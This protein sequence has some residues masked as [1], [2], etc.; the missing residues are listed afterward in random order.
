MDD[1]QALRLEFEQ[2]VREHFP[3]CLLPLKAAL[4]VVAINSFQHNQQPVTLIF[5]G[6]SSSGKTL[7]LSLINPSCSDEELSK[8][9][10]RCDSF[11]AKS[12]VSHCANKTKAELDEMDL[13]PRIENKTLITKELA[14]IFGQKEDE[15]RQTFSMLTSILDGRG[16][17]SNSGSQGQRGYNR[18]INFTW[19]GATT[20]PTNRAFRVMAQ[21]G[22][23][24]M[25]F[26]TFRKGKAPMIS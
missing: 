24:L 12:F 17:I 25:F 4:A 15:L 13:L 6:P 14:P 18:P 16:Y 1:L 23:R 7:V 2:K 3:E 20:P 11:T 8:C 21:L 10:Y 9:L 26:D 22:T 5:S 19:L